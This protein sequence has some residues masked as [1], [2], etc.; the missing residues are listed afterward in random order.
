MSL[1]KRTLLALFLALVCLNSLGISVRNVSPIRPIPIIIRANW[2]LAEIATGVGMKLESLM[3]L[4]SIKDPNSISP[5]QVLQTYPYSD[6]NQVL[7]SW[8]QDGK[9]RAD[10]QP[11]NPDDPTI[12]AHKWL[13]FGTRVQLIREDNGQ[14]IIVVVRDRGPYVAGRDFDLSRGAAEK[15]GIIE[16]GVVRC[17]VKV[18][19]SPE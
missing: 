1:L 11:F 13:P 16:K 2:S 6:W 8:Y 17:T 10:G 15:L 18:I 12:V 5:G 3:Q 14:S 19:S 9:V 4:N 7:V